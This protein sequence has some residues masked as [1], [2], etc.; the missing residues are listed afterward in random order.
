[1]LINGQ[2]LDAEGGE[3][4][5]LVMERWGGL[6]NSAD[7]SEQLQSL[8]RSLDS[9]EYVEKAYATQTVMSMHKPAAAA[10]MVSIVNAKTHGDLDAFTR[11][12]AAHA[13]MASEDREIYP[14]VDWDT[15]RAELAAV[16]RQLE[17]LSDAERMSMGRGEIRP[18]ADE[19]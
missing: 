7:Y 10:A 16:I 13:R 14:L 17:T 19:R 2:Q 5:F 12:N 9:I 4:Q 11:R 8:R 1:M 6:D 18:F 3:Q 15:G